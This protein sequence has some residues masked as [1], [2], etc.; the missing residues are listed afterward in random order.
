[1][2]SKNDLSQLKVNA[3]STLQNIQAQ[4]IQTIKGTAGRKPK[5]LA[6]KQSEMIGLRF[7]KQEHQL[8]KE[9][10]GLV[11]IA[12]YLKNALFTQTDIFK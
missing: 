1:M 8:I 12:T 3:K 9:K 2:P 11:P 4:T 10:A 5:P 6:E 7:T